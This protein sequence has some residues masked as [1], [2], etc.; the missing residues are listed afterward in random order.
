[1]QQN[2]HI[3]IVDVSSKSAD[4]LRIGGIARFTTIDFP[5]RLSAVIFIKGC[6]W[7]CAYCQNPD[8][9]AREFAPQD[10]RLDWVT[11]KGFLSTRK[12]LLDGVV[13]SGGEPCVDP[14]LN[15]AVRETKDLGFQVGLHTG[16]MYPRRVSEILPYLDWVGLDIKAPLSDES[17]Y[18]KVVGKK[19][20]ASHV[21]RT[22]DM[23]LQS[24][25]E[26]EVRTTVHPDLLSEE[27]I[28]KIAD[29]L[30]AKKVQT[31]ALQVYRQPNGMDESE[32]LP[33]VGS[34]YPSEKLITHLSH[35]FKNFIF[36][37]S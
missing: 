37:R 9:Q 33:R 1:M 16:G 10:E 11:I 29:E 12:G 25:V 13:F 31:F 21:E 6:P 20:A 35:R 19:E 17:A 18:E 3:E 24:P 27:Q 26:L 36:R 14:A 8:L 30:L 5:N 2:K 4:E 34:D 7:R 15:E 22:L 28:A 32:V 23:L